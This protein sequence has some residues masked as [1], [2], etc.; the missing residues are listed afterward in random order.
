MI[1]PIQTVINQ[2][3]NSPIMLALLNSFNASLD[4]HGDVCGF[5][6]SVSGNVLTVTAMSFG[7]IVLGVPIHGVAIDPTSLIIESQLSGAT[8]GAGTYRLNTSASVASSY[9]SFGML[10]LFYSQVWNFATAQG[11]GLDV[12]GRIVGVSRLITLPPSMLVNFGFEES[13]GVQPFGQAPFFNGSTPSSYYELPDAQFRQL[14]MTKALANVSGGDAHSINAILQ[15]I[16]GYLGTSYVAEVG[17]MTMYFVFQ[18]LLSPLNESI[19]LQSGLL[20]RPAGVEAYLLNG[21]DAAG[22]FGFAGTGLQPFGHGT[23]FAGGLYP[24]SPQPVL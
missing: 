5:I 10:D 14:I 17:N 12:W 4:P 1:S 11:Y 2:Y 21:I 19:L 3:A 13:V 15:S 9:I 23:L 18:F 20:P 24:I 6:G 8:G 22:N 16:F 7:T